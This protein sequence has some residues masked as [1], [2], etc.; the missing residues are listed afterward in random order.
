MVRLLHLRQ[1][2]S[3][4]VS[5]VLRQDPPGCGA[6]E[7]DRLVYRRLP[8]WAIGRLLVW[9]AGRPGRPQIPLHRDIDRNGLGDGRHRPDTHL[10]LHWPFR[11]LYSVR[12]EN[13]PG[14]LPG[15]GIRWRDNVRCRA[16]FGRAPGILH[17]LAADLADAGYRSFPRGD[18]RYPDLYGR[19]RLQ[20]MGLSDSVPDLIPAGDDGH[21]HPLATGGNSNFPG[22][23][24]KWRYG[25]EP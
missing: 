7:H 22:N 5:Q 19:S 17:R 16:R 9:M 3:D 1:P 11:G 18:R 21:L 4:P 15:R 13:D 23:E 25:N 20:R 14:A 12:P 2:G 6:A 10:R 8:D 24:G